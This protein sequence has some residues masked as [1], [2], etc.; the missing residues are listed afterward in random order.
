MSIGRLA[1]AL[2]VAGLVTA[3]ASAQSTDCVVIDD[4]KAAS[5]GQLPSEWKLRKDEGKGVYTVQEEGGLRFLRATSRGLGIQAA[6]AFEWD[7]AAY[8]IL[9]WAWRPQQFPKGADERR[10]ETNDSALSVYVVVP[11][12]KIR[13]PKAVKYVWSERVPVGERLN[14]NQGLTQV[15][16]LREGRDGAGQWKEERVNARDDYRAFFNESQT[17][18]AAG[19]AVLTDA[20]DTQSTAA[21]DYAN[22]R[23]CRG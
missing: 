2:A 5:V 13:G 14:S 11:Y 12:S 23:A 8:P 6:R 22:F 17:P 19:I 3:S 20:D 18:R 1:S 16:V 4:F 21:G 9:A 10:S 15:R 7:L